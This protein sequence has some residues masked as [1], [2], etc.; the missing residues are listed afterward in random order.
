MT[1]HVPCCARRSPCLRH[2]RAAA[3]H[4]ATRAVHVCTRTAP[5]P[6]HTTAALCVHTCAPTSHWS[7]R[8]ERWRSTYACPSRHTCT[9]AN[10]RH[11][12]APAP[13]PHCAT[14]LRWPRRRRVSHRA[15]RVPSPRLLCTAVVRT[16]PAHGVGH[17]PHAASAQAKLAASLHCT[18]RRCTRPCHHT[19]RH[20]RH[21][22]RR[23]AC[24]TPC[25]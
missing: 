24:T 25:G 5:L 10:R 20:A 23:S 3:D 22:C 12:G 2:P 4:T 13:H 7:P 15:M 9:R 19:H 11:A 18:T 8:H 21:S 17:C 6:Q 14:P 16:A 1:P